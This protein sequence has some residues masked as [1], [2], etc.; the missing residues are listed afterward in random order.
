MLSDGLCAAYYPLADDATRNFVDL[1]TIP[2]DI[3]DRVE[4][5]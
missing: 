5:R 4:V 1:N 2:D 3:V